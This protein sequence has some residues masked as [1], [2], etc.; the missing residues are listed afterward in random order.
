M[1]AFADVLKG[2]GKVKKIGYGGLDKAL[3]I[4]RQERM[5]MFNGSE[6]YTYETLPLDGNNERLPLNAALYL[7]SS[8]VDPVESLIDETFTN[9]L[10]ADVV[11]IKAQIIRLVAY[12]RLDLTRAIENDFWLAQLISRN[13]LLNNDIEKL[14]KLDKSRYLI[15]FKFGKHFSGKNKVEQF[16]D[17]IKY[18]NKNPEKRRTEELIF[19]SLWGTAISST[20]F[21]FNTRESNYSEE[22]FKVS[23]LISSLELFKQSLESNIP[24][25]QQS[26]HKHFRSLVGKKEFKNGKSMI[27]Y[28][29]SEA[30]NQ[31]L[32]RYQGLEVI[33]MNQAYELIAKI[34]LAGD[35]IDFKD[36][37]FGEDSKSGG[38]KTI[39]DRI[40]TLLNLNYAPPKYN[41]SALKRWFKFPQTP[42]DNKN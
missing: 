10:C 4:C 32:L 24:M 25:S 2:Y 38:K 8:V 22:D 27:I 1:K 26:I 40:R 42:A 36:D 35:I 30:M 41:Q 12:N 18:Y 31:V 6:D 16:N 17:Q 34:G 14:S 7:P 29:F 21:L 11:S 5:R 3:D 9:P 19:D 23:K 20:Y 15:P 39:H 37:V 28:Q 13:E 33:G